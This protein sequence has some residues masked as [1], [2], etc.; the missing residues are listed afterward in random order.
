MDW[1][2]ILISMRTAGLSI[3]FTFF[4]GILAAWMVVRISHPLVKTI[5]DGIFTIPLVLPPT[6]AGFFLLYVFGVKRPVGQFFLEYFSVKI[7]FSWGATVLAAV[8]IL[9]VL[10]YRPFC[11]WLC[12]LGAFYALFNKVS[13]FQM[14]VDK[15]KCVSCGKCAKACKMDVDVTKTPDHPECIR[16]GMC[17][18]ACPTGA[19]SFRCGLSRGAKEKENPAGKQA[20][21][22]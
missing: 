14:K 8:V 1:S 7:A 12:P 9:S 5:L 21:E 19:V 4:M 13:L 18:K 20:V 10:F 11:K 6:V 3:V 15:N 22:K 2:P 16:C 17:V